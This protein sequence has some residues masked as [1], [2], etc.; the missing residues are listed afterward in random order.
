MKR[1][2]ALAMG[3]E[4]GTWGF[5]KVKAGIGK[6]EACRDEPTTRRPMTARR[7]SSKW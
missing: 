2:S 1:Y 7:Y 6:P 5:C 4:M 3:H